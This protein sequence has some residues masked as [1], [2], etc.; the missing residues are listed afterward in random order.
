[1]AIPEGFDELVVRGPGCW[2]WKGKATRDGHGYFRVGSRSRT[3][4][5]L[6]WESVNGPVPERSRVLRKCSTVGCVNPEHLQLYRFKEPVWNECEN[7]NRL[8]GL[9][10]RLRKQLGNR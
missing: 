10:A 2:A 9:V 8:A 7:C 3:A 4:A 5:A 6:A 1:M